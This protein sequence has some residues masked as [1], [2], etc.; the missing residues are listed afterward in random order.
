[1][2]PTSLCHSSQNLESLGYSKIVADGLLALANDDSKNPR[3]RRLAIE[4][5]ADLPQGAHVIN[6][7]FR[8]AEDDLVTEEV[9]ATATQRVGKIG[10][11]KDNVRRFSLLAQDAKSPNSVRIEAVLAVGRP[12]N[13]QH[14]A[15]TLE[16]L[17]EDY[18]VPIDVRISAAIALANTIVMRTPPL[19]FER[20]SYTVRSADNMKSLSWRQDE[21][22]A[23]CFSLFD[24]DNPHD[25]RLRLTAANFL[26]IEW[27]SMQVAMLCKLAEDD[28]VDFS[29]RASAIE[30][31]GQLL[32]GT[33]ASLLTVPR[34]I[35]L[36]LRIFLPR[37]RIPPARDESAAIMLKLSGD[38]QLNNS[39]RALAALEA[40]E[41]GYSDRAAL[42]MLTFAEDDH[43]D[44]AYR[45]APARAAG[46]LGQ[47]TRA[48][49]VLIS[50]TQDEQLHLY[51]RIAAARTL[52][53][54]DMKERMVDLTLFL[55]NCDQK[56]SLLQ[57]Q[58]LVKLKRRLCTPTIP[59]S[60]ACSP[61]PSRLK[62]IH[63]S[64]TKPLTNSAASSPLIAAPHRQTRRHNHMDPEAQ[65]RLREAVA[66]DY[67]YR[68]DRPK[69][70]SI[71]RELADENSQNIGWHRRHTGRRHTLE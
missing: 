7:L 24:E 26:S 19:G 71:L 41:L 50:F 28:K 45:I 43:T 11:N 15:A 40:G 64:A 46:L 25:V 51:T 49:A 9:R 54:I 62:R 33:T 35:G 63:S 38:K 2:L 21:R 42:M 22:I 52:G 53:H 57:R 30:A 47:R 12:E 56:D 69:I 37:F 14:V 65:Q 44:A 10:M 16:M 5:I 17:F 34:K 4:K 18:T 27:P 66:D 13:R 29:V 1:M 67:T 48:A 70:A 39:L 31:A 23:D 36:G 60:T 3:T 59:S 68:R 8:I 32:R 61:S 6:E 20:G 55:A 58:A